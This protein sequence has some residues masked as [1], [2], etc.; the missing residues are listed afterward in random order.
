MK[1]RILS[2]LFFVI[3]FSFCFCFTSCKKDT[4]TVTVI[5][6]V[7]KT[8][9]SIEEIALNQKIEIA[10]EKNTTIGYIPI[11]T[12]SAQKYRFLGW[13]TDASYTY[14]WNTA[15]DIVIGDM[16]LYAK[17]EKIS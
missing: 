1:K 8:S 17:W 7:P 6:Y 11:S 4:C 3:L 16:T 14:Q 15:T 2:T 5:S 9:Y 12:Y 10:V 13:Y